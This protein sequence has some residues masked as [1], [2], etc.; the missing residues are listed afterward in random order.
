MS[1]TSGDEKPVLCPERFAATGQR[2][3]A[4]V[5]KEVTLRDPKRRRVV[6][7][8]KCSW[9]RKHIRRRKFKY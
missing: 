2:E 8:Q 1:L 9:C 4:F 6:I 7:V 3:H 5:G